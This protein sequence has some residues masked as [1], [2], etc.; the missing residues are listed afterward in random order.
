MCNTCNAC[1]NCEHKNKF[2]PESVLNICGGKNLFEKDCCGFVNP[3]TMQGIF[4]SVCEDVNHPLVFIQKRNKNC[5]MEKASENIESV[6]QEKYKHEKSRCHVCKKSNSFYDDY[7][8]LES[9]IFYSRLSGVCKFVRKEKDLEKFTCG[10]QRCLLFDS[11]AAAFFLDRKSLHEKEEEEEK[12]L[13]KCH[14]KNERLNREYL[15]YLCPVTQYTELAIPVMLEGKTVGVLIFGQMLKENDK[16]NYDKFLDNFSEKLKSDVEFKNEK[17]SFYN[18]VYNEIEFAKKIED[19]INSVKKLEVRLESL[20]EVYRKWYIDEISHELLEKFPKATTISIPNGSLVSTGITETKYEEFK[21]SLWELANSLCKRMSISKMICF[22]PNILQNAINNPKH[23]Y[24]INPNKHIESSKL[25]FNL[26]KFNS[27]YPNEQEKIVN[28][29]HIKEIVSNLGQNSSE[30]KKLSFV[31]YVT[32]RKNKGVMPI[33]VLFGY[34]KKQIE[35]AK[36]TKF[37]HE[38][39][40]LI[41]KIKDPVYVMASSIINQYM[42]LEQRRFVQV[43]RHELGQSYAGYLTLLEQFEEEF[44]TT[45]NDLGDSPNRNAALRCASKAITTAY[46]YTKNSRTYAHTTMLRVNGTRY[47]GGVLIPNKRYFYPYGEFLFKWNYIFSETQK[48]K[49]LKFKMPTEDVFSYPEEYPLMYADPDMI[50]QIAFNLTNNAMKYSHFGSAVT[51]NCFADK[52]KNKYILEVINY[53]APLHE[54][55][56]KLIFNYGYSGKNHHEKGSGLGLYISNEIAKRHEGELTVEQEII[57]N[58][59]VPLLQ[60]YN[61]NMSPNMFSLDMFEKVKAEICRLKQPA[62]NNQP[63][64][65]S[66]ILGEPIPQNP[67]TDLY[68]K[69]NIEKPTARIKFTL[70]IPLYK[71]KDEDNE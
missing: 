30:F 50:E 57:S 13:E 71:N 45:L 40:S 37:I 49:Y 46:L 32:S 54:E 41:L 3:E 29:K 61:E 65:W 68:I 20:L 62:P 52:S 8:R 28:Q 7:Y 43:M 17:P 63:S 27:L 6:C 22:I 25:V 26:E 59:N 33:S 10:F 64:A 70:S 39:D 58:F 55:E 53:A 44:Y 56:E 19:C 42:E 14:R 21:T 31:L 15:E 2:F 16:N 34:D 67:F 4:L 35:K 9:N 38:L 48:S 24:D 51:L 5:N 18:K 23:L 1:E 66:H 11:Y 47:S 60:L 36:K 12:R 69:Q